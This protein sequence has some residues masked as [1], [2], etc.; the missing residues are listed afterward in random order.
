MLDTARGL[1]GIPFIINSGLRT[2]T[3]N[4]MLPEAVNDSSH[5][6]GN[7]VD[8]ACSDSATRY[9]MVSALLASGFTRIGIYATHL[10]A[11]NSTDRVQKVI[12]R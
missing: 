12:W 6:T 3:Q 2:K 9:R 10:H 7:A 11:D 8:L 5:L 4:D 1:S